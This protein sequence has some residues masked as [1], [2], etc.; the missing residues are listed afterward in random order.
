VALGSTYNTNKHYT[1]QRDSI[2]Q[3]SHNDRS[4]NQYNNIPI[5]KINKITL[6][7][8][9]AP[10]QKKPPKIRE[11]KSKYYKTNL[12]RHHS[13]IKTVSTAP[14]VDPTPNQRSVQWVAGLFPGAMGPGGS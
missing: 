8:L 11:I 10:P 7:K 3:D 1:Q 12:N 6:N 9:R 13:K 2:E 14:L 5:N 4:T